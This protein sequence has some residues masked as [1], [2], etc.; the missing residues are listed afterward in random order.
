MDET[1][2]VG[3]AG[4]SFSVSSISDSASSNKVDSHG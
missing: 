2:K 3:I 4:F 1:F